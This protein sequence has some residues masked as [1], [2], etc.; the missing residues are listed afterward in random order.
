M[1]MN[2]TP[3]L[4]INGTT[5]LMGVFPLATW[6]CSNLTRGSLGSFSSAGTFDAR[7]TL[8]CCAA[9]ICLAIVC[10]TVASF[11]VVQSMVCALGSPFVG[12]PYVPFSGNLGVDWIS[13]NAVF[14]PRS[15]ARTPLVCPRELLVLPVMG[16]S[17]L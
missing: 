16:S 8:G 6:F 7:Y 9:N 4:E 2:F 10:A 3:A 14:E 5:P 11:K 12:N 13:Q 17:S 15:K 1:D